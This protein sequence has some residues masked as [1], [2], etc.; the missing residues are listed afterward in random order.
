MKSG[1][2]I[3]LSFVVLAALIAG[4][5]YAGAGADE[6]PQLTII[7]DRHV[8]TP[9]MSSTVGIGLTPGYPVLV[10]N[11]TVAFRWKTDYGYFISWDA[12][13]YKV[14]NRGQ[15]ITMGDGKIY[16]SY[17]PDDMDKEKPVVHVT[18]L[19]IEKASGRALNTTSIEIGWAD[20][21]TALFRQ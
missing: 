18:L 14:N 9:A 4:Y 6:P 20:K 13:D 16:W 10:D 7:A 11:E 21:H 17:H 1:N 19:M 12:P 15:D 2:A 5:I 8:Y 3:I